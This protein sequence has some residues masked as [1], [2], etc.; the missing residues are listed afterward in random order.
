MLA[1]QRAFQRDSAAET[2][3][4]IVK[5]APPPLENAPESLATIVEHCLEK[6]PGERFQSARDLA[7][8]LASAVGSGSASGRIVPL[9]RVRRARLGVAAVVP[10]LIAAAFF[11]GRRSQRP[12]LPPH[13]R[14]L[15]FERGTLLSARFTPDAKTILYSAAWGGSAADVYS[16]R[17][18]FPESRPLG[19]ENAK[20][21]NVSP[22]GE[23]ALLV[24]ARPLDWFLMQGTLARAP[25]MG[26]APRELMD[27]VLDAAWTPDGSQLAVV[28]LGEGRT[29]LEFPPGKPLH[30]TAGYIDAPR[31]SGQGDRIAF[32][33]HPEQFDTR[34]VVAVVDLEG[35]RRVLTREYEAVEGLAWTGEELWFS[36][37]GPGAV[38]SIHATTLGGRERLVARG[39]GHLRLLD[40]SA[41]GSALVTREQIRQE[42]QA[43]GPGER[44]L[45]DLT[46]LSQASLVDISS[47]GKRVLFFYWGAGAQANY[48]VCVRPTDGGPTVRLGRGS[49]R[50]FSRDGKWATAVLFGPPPVVVLLP[51]GAGE[52]RQVPQGELTG[53][54][55]VVLHPD[56]KRLVV[57]AT[58]P[59]QGTRLFVVDVT[60]GTPPRALS[61]A[62]FVADGAFLSP[63]GRYAVATSPA[64]KPMLVPIDG[65]EPL[66]IAGVGEGDFFA[67]WTAD[68]KAVHVRGSGASIRVHRVEIAGGVRRLV[69]EVVLPERAGV[70]GPLTF[71]M[72]TDA[73]AFALGYGRM[74]SDLFLAE[75]LR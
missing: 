8:Q 13:Y 16:A 45:R 44:G 56:G 50:S 15:T 63:D 42:I 26:G 51:T 11:A 10:L 25:M 65:G 6:S 57:G 64:G 20:L 43:Q 18:D 19:A 54:R 75:G 3:A 34:G 74:L 41:D 68:S 1:G 39:P 70:A 31:F 55:G 9:A 46:Y 24:R 36:A 38:T 62:G 73:D 47:D 35:S 59:A 58:A 40:V 49:A 28:R 27:G 29:R 48:D 66:P 71:V 21:L 72:A 23:M 67:G 60:G 14:Q 30:E 2:M 69:R 32:L 52:A 12:P 4:A 37:A 33:E 22:A 61:P 17:F 7:F 5:E 53:H